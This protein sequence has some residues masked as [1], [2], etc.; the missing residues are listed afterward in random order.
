[1]SLLSASIRAFLLSSIV[2]TALAC[3][4][5]PTV[6]ADTSATAVSA[7]T[8]SATASA[9][10]TS[11]ADPVPTVS[12]VASTSASVDPCRNC[13]WHEPL[14]PEMKKQLSHHTPMPENGGCYAPEHVEGTMHVNRNKCEARCCPD[15]TKGKTSR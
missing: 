11:A 5:P 4:A 6:S 10:V 12:A 8:T 13:Y 2:A 7:V 9:T 15:A 3:D 1:M 14:S